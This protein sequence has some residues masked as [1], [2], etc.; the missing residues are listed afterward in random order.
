MKK[1]RFGNF[2]IL[3]EDDK[4]PKVKFMYLKDFR[5]DEY[6]S[7]FVNKDG[8]ILLRDFLNDVINEF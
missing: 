1:L 2:G 5:A 4:N 3:L 8:L 6:I 7:N